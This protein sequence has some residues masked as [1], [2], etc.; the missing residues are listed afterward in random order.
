MQRRNHPQA[1]AD[2]PAAPRKIIHVDMDAFFASV[3]QRD[4]PQLRGKPV[5]V[6]GQ[7]QGRGVVAACSYEARQFG[8]RSAMPCREALRK[9]PQAIFVRPRFDAYRA[10]S[11]MLRAIFRRYTD[12]VEPLS[13]DE[14][15][16][17]VSDIICSDARFE[18]SA[19]RLAEEIRAAIAAELSL[20]ASAGV[21]Y[22]KFLAKLASDRNKPDGLCVIR[23]GEAVALLAQ[24]PVRKFHGIGRATEARMRAMGIHTGADLMAYG[25]HSL[26]RRFGKAGRY[27]YN[28]VRGIDNRPVNNSRIRKSIGAERTFAVDI[29]EREAA[30]RE[31]DQVLEKVAAQLGERQLRA[32]TLTL[33]VR[34]NDFSTVTRSITPA[35]SLAASVDLREALP[36]LVAKTDIGRRAVRLLGLSVSDLQNG[37]GIAR[38]QLDLWQRRG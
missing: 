32:R 24:L 38:E 36:V 11:Q 17:D 29:T 3:E 34:Y 27:Y 30:W 26:V 10:A 37:D 5:V 14:A 20:T 6:G 8:I 18:G 31:L 28:L 19:T 22:N 25:E 4:N 13:L 2:Q 1:V 35:R 12:L 21:S 23:P 7:P 15:F 33:K 16:L 9:C